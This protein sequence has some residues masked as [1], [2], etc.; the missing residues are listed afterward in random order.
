MAKI[1]ADPDLSAEGKAKRI[2][3]INRGAVKKLADVADELNDHDSVVRE[4][5]TEPLPYVEGYAPQDYATPTIDLA[6]VQ[7]FKAMDQNERSAC[8]A[9]MLGGNDQR[10]TD[11]ILRMPTV[12]TGLSSVVLA[13]LRDAA[14]NRAH[15]EEVSR[16]RSLAAASSAAR[17]MIGRT[18]DHLAAKG[19]LT[20]QEQRELLGDAAKHFP[21][22]F[23]PRAAS[24]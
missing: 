17:T 16:R 2:A 14:V 1:N 24:R 15:P 8:L 10:M 7:A 6:L 4:Q 13:N 12:L 5:V 9:R 23:D 19:R 11:A 3:E 20:R 18:L 21:H 22:L